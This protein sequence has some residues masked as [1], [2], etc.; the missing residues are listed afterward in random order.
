MLT[1]PTR[2]DITP[3]IPPNMMG[4]ARTMA[5]PKMN[6]T[7]TRSPAASQP[8]SAV[9]AISPKTRDHHSGT[10]RFR[11]THKKANAVMTKSRIPSVMPTL[12]DIASIAGRLIAE[13]SALRVN[14]TGSARPKIPNPKNTTSAKNA[15]SHG[16]FQLTLA[17]ASENMPGVTSVLMPAPPSCS[18]AI[19]VDPVPVWKRVWEA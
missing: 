16:A 8:K 11:N 18:D 4:I 3:A 12:L 19:S 7:G 2:S 10:G 9:T 5:L 15:I 1:T 14:T 6:A 17:S 13:S